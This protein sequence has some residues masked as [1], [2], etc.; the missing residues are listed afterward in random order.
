M[1]GSASPG[2]EPGP[3]PGGA[4]QGGGCSRRSCRCAARPAAGTGSKGGGAR[5]WAGGPG[6]GA[7]PRSG[8]RRREAAGGGGPGVGPGRGGPGTAP[9][10]AAGGE[11][12]EAGQGSP[13]LSVQ[14]PRY[15]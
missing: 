10:S 12:F 3:W 13:A 2:G 5:R 4:G 14:T 7:G 15:C 11:R 6:P 8:R 9:L 1:A